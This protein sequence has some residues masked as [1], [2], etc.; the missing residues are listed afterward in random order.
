MPFF[1]LP[2][3]LFHN[4]STPETLYLAISAR[5]VYDLRE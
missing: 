5:W 3:H 1:L 4:R 2:R